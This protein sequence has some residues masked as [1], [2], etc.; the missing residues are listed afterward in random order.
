MLFNV[1]Q[2]AFLMYNVRIYTMEVV[3]Q[4]QKLC[5]LL[6]NSLPIMRTVK[7]FWLCVTAY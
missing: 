4:K 2:Y 5:E 3:H 7:K 6:K 1:T